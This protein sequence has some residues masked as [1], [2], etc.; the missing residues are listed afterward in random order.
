MAIRDPEKFEQHRL[1]GTLHYVLNDHRFA[2]GRIRG[3]N[4]LEPM[5]EFMML[6]FVNSAASLQWRMESETYKRSGPA[7]SCA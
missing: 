2:C 6:P 7:K 5:A 1:S 3:A 4:Y